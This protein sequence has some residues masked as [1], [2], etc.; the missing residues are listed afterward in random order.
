MRRPAIGITCSFQQTDPPNPRLQ[1]RLNAAYS[2]AV[3]A[4]GGLPRPIALPAEPE[5]SLLDDLLSG[6]DGVIFSGGLDLDPQRYG[7]TRHPKAELMH[8]RRD[9]FEFT[10]FRRAD[11]LRLPILAIC[12]GYQVAHVARGGRLIQHL[13]DVPRTPAIAHHL[14]HGQA[15]HEVTLAPGS[16]LAQIIGTTR[17]EVNSRHHQAV[18]PDYAG[19]GLRPVA[20]APD[21]VLE[22]AEDCESRHL[23]GVQWHPE[24]LIDRREHLCLF[25]DLVEHAAE[26]GSR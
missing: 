15:F 3:F 12:L 16:R 25:A 4:A 8:E 20:F 9:R 26:K 21:G 24:D 11:E 5:P 6:L 23:L 14:R 7:Q 1:T 19:R 13:D 17:L 10:L 22:A 18:D 2:D